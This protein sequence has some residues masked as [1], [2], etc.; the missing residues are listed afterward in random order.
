MGPV[1]TKLLR[2]VGQGA[3]ADLLAGDTK[4]LLATYAERIQKLEWFK[5]ELGFRRLS[6]ITPAIVAECRQ[7]L[8][9]ELVRDKP[10]S[11]PT[12]NRYCSQLSAVFEFAKDTLYW[13]K[14][15]PVRE[16]KWEKENDGVVRFLSDEEKKRLLEACAQDKEPLMLAIVV[17]ALS[18]GLRKEE[19]RN[20]TWQEV[21]LEKG[22]IILP[23]TR[24]K[25]RTSRSLL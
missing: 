8:K 9:A 25:N 18:T 20:L 19:L 2:D 7:K 21:D 4:T 1:V 3:A 14:K 5:K 24:T 22:A 17:T 6:D 23:K 12:C 16:V 10:R 11:G 15:N 13:T